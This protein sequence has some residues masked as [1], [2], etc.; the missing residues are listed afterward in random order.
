MRALAPLLLAAAACL[1]AG[2]RA[3]DLAGDDAS[4]R[5]VALDLDAAREL[6]QEGVR[7]FRDGR[8]VD[9]IRYFR[10][11]Y[12]LGGPPSEL[13]NVARC[14]ERMDDAEGAAAA[15]EQYLAQRDL[16]PQD[17]AEAEREVAA[18][19][20]RPSVLTVITSPP[21]AI[22][23]V[24]GRAIAPP[25]PVSIEIRAGAHSIA[26]HHDGFATE[27]RPLEARFGRAVLVS[28]LLARASSGGR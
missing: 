15:I 17:R 26:V 24:D 11:A 28:L 1:P 16:S 12:R 21:G 22:V 13:W 19:R 6:D 14:R 2:S 20:G 23:I 8:Y 18:L 3:R 5:R 9:A 25:T 27:T 10:A 7:S 4:I